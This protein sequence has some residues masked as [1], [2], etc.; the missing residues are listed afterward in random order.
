[1]IQ[2]NQHQQSV[3][4]KYRFDTNFIHR[5]EA[6]GHSGTYSKNN[7]VQSNQLS[8]LNYTKPT[9]NKPKNHNNILSN[10]INFDI[11]TQSTLTIHSFHLEK[12]IN[13]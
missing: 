2:L 13:L 4:D 11:S 10:I 8:W 3:H 5:Y 7:Q 1:M 6:Q 9:N 12:K